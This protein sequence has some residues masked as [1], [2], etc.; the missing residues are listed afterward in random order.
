MFSRLPL[1]VSR[2]IRT[3]EN[4]ASGLLT[5]PE[6]LLIGKLVTLLSHPFTRREDVVALLLHLS[7][8]DGSVFL[9]E[10]KVHYGQPPGKLSH[11][12]V[13]TSGA[14][15]WMRTSNRS[16]DSIGPTPLGVPVRITSPG[17]SVRL[18]EMKLTRW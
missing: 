14:S 6:S 2:V 16:P 3:A 8:A 5:Q 11:F 13:L 4:D 10:A 15:P 12:T 9:H 18:V 17:N 1:F 7:R